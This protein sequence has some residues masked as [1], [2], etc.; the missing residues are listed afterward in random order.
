MVNKQ[1]RAPEAS[2]FRRA[3]PSLHPLILINPSWQPLYCSVTSS[4]AEQ[5]LH[6][7]FDAGVGNFAINFHVAEVS[8]RLYDTF[9]SY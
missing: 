3:H 6:V 8:R 5:S 2:P 1:L 4:G 7:L 9:Y